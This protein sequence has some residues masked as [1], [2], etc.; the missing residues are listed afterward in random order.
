MGFE[1]INARPKVAK[2]FF[3]Q[4]A[5]E[6]TR[7]YLS[8]KKHSRKQ[9]SENFARQNNKWNVGQIAEPKFAYL[10]KDDRKGQEEAMFRV[11]KEQFGVITGQCR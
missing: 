10:S 4:W 11:Q 1:I 9:Q 8:A 7:L 5:A 3:L 6:I 2:V